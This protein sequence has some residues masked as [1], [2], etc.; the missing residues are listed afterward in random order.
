MLAALLV[1]RVAGPGPGGSPT[2][3]GRRA[4]RASAPPS[5][6]PVRRHGGTLLR[7]EAGGW[8][9][10]FDGAARAGDCA[11]ALRAAAA[12]ARLPLAQGLHVGEVTPRRAAGG[13]AALTAEAVAGR[14]RPGEILAHRPRRRLAAGSGL[15]FADAGTL[16]V[17][18]VERPVGLAALVAE[19][20]LD[21]AARR[22]GPPGPRPA[23]RPRARGARARRRRPQQRRH[24]RPPRRSASTPP[25]VTSP[26]SS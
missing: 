10:R 17:A 2:A 9:A 13:I 11:V 21:P 22:R 5:R 24:R 12:A 8:L 14:A 18:G 4:S 6:R 15:Y 1:A 25:S 16:A 23:Q 20:H 3:A 7:G 26:T 19:R